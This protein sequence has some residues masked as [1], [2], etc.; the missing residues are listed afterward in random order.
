MHTVLP[1]LCKG[2]LYLLF[3]S[4]EMN[5]LIFKLAFYVIIFECVINCFALYTKC[6]RAVFRRILRQPFR[7]AKETTVHMYNKNIG[8]IHSKHPHTQC[9]DSRMMYYMHYSGTDWSTSQE[10]SINPLYLC[11]PWQAEEKW[12]RRTPTHALCSPCDG[13][14]GCVCIFMDY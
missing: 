11:V 1:K 13:G 3:S 10:G 6:V 4:S 7:S 8:N 14:S 2:L 9:A 12:Y 5:N